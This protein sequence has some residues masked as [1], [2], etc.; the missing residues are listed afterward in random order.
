MRKHECPITVGEWIRGRRKALDLTQ[1]ELALR[2]GCSKFALR[3]IEAG[4]RRP[5]NQLAGLLTGALEISLE[6]QQMFTRVSRG[7]PNLERLPTVDKIGAS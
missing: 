4:E 3:K 5:S 7:E 6:D 2:A 1:E